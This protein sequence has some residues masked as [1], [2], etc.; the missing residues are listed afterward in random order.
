MTLFYCIFYESKALKI[1]AWCEKPVVRRPACRFGI[2]IKYYIV[3]YM[4]H[5]IRY[6]LADFQ[7]SRVP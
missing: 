2:W 3:Q 1:K 7:N 5:Q 6:P 4:A